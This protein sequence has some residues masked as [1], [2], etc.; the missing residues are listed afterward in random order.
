[1]KTIRS[2]LLLT[3]ISVAAA[4]GCSGT[5][6]TVPGIAEVEGKVLSPQGSPLKGGTLVLRPMGGIR[7]AIS[8]EIETDGTFV[9]DGSTGNPTVL[10]G[11][12]EVYVVV[13][14]DPQERKLQQQ[15]PLKYRKLSDEDSDLLVSLD[16]SGKKLVVKLKRG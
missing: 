9:I 14:D 7:R 8:A 12:Y 4:V 16:D 11:D 3:L 13:S 10:P 1:M 6:P 2:G 15:I 5:Q